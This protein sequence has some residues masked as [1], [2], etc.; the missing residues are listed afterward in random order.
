MSSKSPR[1]LQKTNYYGYINWISVKFSVSTKIWALPWCLC[2]WALSMITKARSTNKNPSRI[3]LMFNNRRRRLKLNNIISLIL[4]GYLVRIMS[5]IEIQRYRHRQILFHI[6]ELA[7]W[8]DLC[9]LW[10]WN[11]GILS[12]VM[13]SLYD[14]SLRPNHHTTKES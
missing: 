6:F 4:R 10:S 12:E 9:Y 8:S 14:L 7:T 13:W 11:F 1:S 5:I 2:E 3:C